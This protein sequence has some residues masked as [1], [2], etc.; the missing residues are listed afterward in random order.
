MLLGQIIHQTISLQQITIKS[1]ADA[2]NVHATEE[3]IIDMV[4]HTFAESAIISGQHDYV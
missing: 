4:I 3:I 2:L 1:C